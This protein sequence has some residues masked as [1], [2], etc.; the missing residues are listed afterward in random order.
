MAGWVQKDLTS[1]EKAIAQGVLR[2]QYADR[3][4]Q[5]RS[6]AEML[7]IRD[8]IRRELG[9]VESPNPIYIQPRFSRE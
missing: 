3:V 5:Y 4:V 9:L 6:L 8:I 1:L 2:V 7:Q